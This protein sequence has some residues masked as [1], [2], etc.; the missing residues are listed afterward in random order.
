KIY[1]KRKNFDSRTLYNKLSIKFY[2]NHSSVY[3]LI[4][5]RFFLS[6]T[7][8]FPL[9]FNSFSV[10][11]TFALFYNDIIMQNQQLPSIQRVFLESVVSTA[12]PEGRFVE[13]DGILT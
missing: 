4:L 9:Y 1:N 5:F 13:V 11:T 12:D 2:L 10:T 3:L 8:V 7:F 6:H